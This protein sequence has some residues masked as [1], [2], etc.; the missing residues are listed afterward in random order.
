MTAQTLRQLRAGREDGPACGHTAHPA[1]TADVE[2]ALVQGMSRH[3]ARH[4]P[5]P[6]T[7]DDFWDLTFPHESDDNGAGVGGARR[8]GG[9]GGGGGEQQEDPLATSQDNI[10]AADHDHDAGGRAGSFQPMELPSSGE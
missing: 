10:N 7:P 6:S 5:P 3:R 4:V 2:Q 8:G 1:T 9:H